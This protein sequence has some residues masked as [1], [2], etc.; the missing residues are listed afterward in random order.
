MLVIVLRDLLGFVPVRR[1]GNSSVLPVL[2]Y[3]NCG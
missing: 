2:K 3:T 1:R